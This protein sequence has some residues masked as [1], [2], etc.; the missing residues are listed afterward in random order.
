MTIRSRIL[1]GLLLI[2]GAGFYFLIDWILDDV[3]PRYRQVIEESLVDTANTLAVIVERDMETGEFDVEE[4]RSAFDRANERRFEAH[5]YEHIKDQVDLRVYITDEKGIVVFDSS[6]PENEGSDYSQWNDVARTLKGQYGARTTRDNPDDPQTTVLY[7]AA[8]LKREGELIGSLTVAKPTF[9]SNELI[10][11]SQWKILVGSAI[12]ALLILLAG[13]LLTMWITRPLERLAQYARAIGRG[14]RPKFPKLSSGEIGELGDA[15]E[16]MRDTLEGK[17]Y[18]EQYVQSLTHE[19]K[20]PVAA[21]SGA[22]ELLTEKMPEEQRAKFF[23]NI[24][25]ESARLKTI[26]EKV[27]E[28]ASLE[29]R[30]GLKEIERID[31]AGAINHE[32]QALTPLIQA[33]SLIIERNLASGIHVNGEKFLVAQAIRNILSNAIEFSPKGGKIII[34]LSITQGHP[35]V[36]VEDNGSGIPEYALSKVF[37]RFYSTP[38]PD[39]AVKSS[40][41]GLSFVREIMQLHAGEIRLENRPTGGAKATIRF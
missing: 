37:E 23:T 20:S 16:E 22:V 33:K 32:L 18:V 27:L 34:T 8:P 3:K 36:I 12:A 5:I 31:L 11:N 30:K 14:E 15:F 9:S 39:T 10:A 4:L 35:E 1:L 6:E 40:G 41:L 28:L 21:I 38:R 24:Q 17:R 25:N 26:V 13:L 29:S 19:I 2:V 7:V